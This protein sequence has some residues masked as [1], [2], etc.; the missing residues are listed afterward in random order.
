MPGESCPAVADAH[1]DLQ[2]SY[3]MFAIHQGRISRFT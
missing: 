3:S 1:Y 2:P